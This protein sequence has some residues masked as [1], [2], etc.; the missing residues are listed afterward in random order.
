MYM[1]DYRY[2]IDILLFYCIPKQEYLYDKKLIRYMYPL[3][4]RVK[5]IIRNKKKPQPYISIIIASLYDISKELRSFCFVYLFNLDIST[6]LKYMYK[7]QSIKVFISMN[8]S[9]L[10]D[11]LK[12]TFFTK[13]SKRFVSEVLLSSFTILVCW[14]YL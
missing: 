11:N 13:F 2:I 3:F 10:C 1:N 14:I 6:V 9:C 7:V 12:R 8:C 5:N 4:I